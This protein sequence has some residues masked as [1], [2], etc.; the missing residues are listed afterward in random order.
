[1]LLHSLLVLLG[2][3]FGFANPVYHMPPLALLVPA[4]L[5]LL[6]VTAERPALAFRRGWLFGGLGASTALYW[7]AVPIHDHAFVPWALAVPCAVLLGMT[8]GFFSGLYAMA[9]QHVAK[10]LPMLPAALFAGCVWGLLEAAK[11]YA[12]TGF[13]WLVLPVAF[14]PWTLLIQGAAYIGSWGLAGVLAMAAV[15]WAHGRW[16]KSRHNGSALPGAF[17]GGAILT[18]LLLHGVFILQEPAT[19]DG[20]LQVAVVQGNV[21]QS[22]KW[23]EAYQ[24]ETIDRYA[25]LS[26]ESAMTANATPKVIFW[27]ETAMPFYFQEDTPSSRQVRALA[28]DLGAGILLGAPGYDRN[29]E[30]N[31]Y[32]FYNRAYLVPPGSAGLTYYEKEHLV[33][34]G[35]YIPYADIITFLDKIVEGPSD[36]TPGERVAPLWLDQVSMGVLICYETIFPELA[37]KRVAQ[38]ASVLVNISNDAWFGKTSAPTQHLHL[39]VLRAVEQRRSVIRATNTGISAIIEP[40]GVIK[41]D[42]GLFETATFA[43]SVTLK[44]GKSQYHVWADG[45]LPVMAALGMLCFLWSRIGP[46][47]APSKVKQYS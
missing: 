35:E 46:A 12:L 24:Q 17:V 41:L 18:G 14:A 19:N 7:V 1:M 20:L 2:S 3:F 38:G 13:P 21:D 31:Q 42:T 40:S 45:I 6:G 8:L 22:V 28:T 10:R 4:G 36:F 44:R 43:Y 27:P 25:S 37:Y 11:G 47:R 30:T 32:R 39:A 23:N 29:P 16:Q 9:C 5:Y 26:R 15:C 33:P 34:F